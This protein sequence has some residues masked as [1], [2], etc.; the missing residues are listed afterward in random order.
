MSTWRVIEV[1]IYYYF[2]TNYL[3]CLII[4]LAVWA[5]DARQTWLRRV[6]APQWTGWREEPNIWTDTSPQTVYIHALVYIANTVSHVA[7]GEITAVTVEERFGN[8]FICIFGTFMYSWLFGNIVALVAGMAPGT[9]LA[10]H[11]RYNSVMQK[12][13]NDK[14]PDKLVKSVNSYFDYEW[15]SQ[16]GFDEL[17]LMSELP[18]SIRA[19]IMLIRY[20]DI[21]ESSLIFRENEGKIDIALTNSIFRLLKIEVFMRNQFLLKI[22]HISEDSFIILNGEVSVHGLFLNENLGKLFPGSHVSVSLDEKAQSEIVKKANMSLFNPD[23]IIAQMDPADNLE[24]KATFHLV[25][26]TFVQVGVLTV[27]DL[28]VLFKAY[29]EWKI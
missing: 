15:S 27:E 3:S 19:D 6:P 25:A 29:P 23:S 8:C 1:I 5:P 14:I 11:R 22:G 21:I 24:G 18:S 12:L 13:K 26:N 9:H 20:Q 4:M 7:V 17:D 16:K 28:Q 2:I 10:F